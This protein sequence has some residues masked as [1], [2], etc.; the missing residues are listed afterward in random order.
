MISL[1]SFALVAF[2]PLA[3]AAC[4]RGSTVAI[5]LTDAPIDTSTIAKVEVSLGAVEIQS[6]SSCH[7]GDHDGARKDGDG[8]GK[9]IAV[10]DKA[11]TFDLLSLTDGKTAPLGEAEVWGDVRSIRMGIDTAG[12][13][14][15]VLK[16]GRT[17]ALDT[18]GVTQARIDL[19]EGVDAIDTTH[20]G[21]TTV[22]VDFVVEESL[23]E[24]SSCNFRLTPVLDIKSVA[25]AEED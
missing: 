11:G 4:G 17:C 14:Q 16:D 7:G 22:V 12:T 8:E 21:R 1:R 24:V 15:V 5:E 20:G 18:T 10:N 6:G 2:A 13:N 19:A 23:V 3:L 9:W 25:H